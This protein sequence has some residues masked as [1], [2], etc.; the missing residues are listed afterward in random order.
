MGASQG[1]GERWWPVV[2][3]DSA[4]SRRGEELR[5]ACRDDLAVPRAP[6]PHPSARMEFPP[7]TVELQ[8]KGQQ[9]RFLCPSLPDV[10]CLLAS[11]RPQSGRESVDT[12]LPKV[13]G[14][15]FPRGARAQAAEG[16]QR[17]AAST[18]RLRPRRSQVWGARRN[19]GAN[20]TDLPAAPPRDCPGRTCPPA[21]RRQSESCARR[22]GPVSAR[23]RT[24]HAR[25]TSEASALL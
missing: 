2:L 21:C 15:P 17:R 9:D 7:K 19:V 1:P 3:P 12:E 14:R 23:G 10:K 11:V 8:Q 6:A 13:P 18:L 20:P 22:S 24:K 25:A 4:A 16:S 5:S